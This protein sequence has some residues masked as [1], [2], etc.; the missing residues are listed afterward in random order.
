MLYFSILV[1]VYLPHHPQLH[2]WA[3]GSPLT[4][5]T[6]SEHRPSML[7]QCGLMGFKDYYNNSVIIS[8]TDEF[9]RHGADTGNL[10]IRDCAEKENTQYLIEFCPTRDSS[11][12]PRVP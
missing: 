1:F 9:T 10:L 11:P 8:G 5:E 4:G 6:V 7:L 3:Q 12:G 2:C